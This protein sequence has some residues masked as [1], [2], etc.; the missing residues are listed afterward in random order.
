MTLQAVT[1]LELE[2]N[3]VCNIHSR[4]QPCP[5]DE[6]VL[7]LNNCSHLNGVSL[8]ACG[9][10]DGHIDGLLHM[11]GTMYRWCVATFSSGLSN[12][13]SPVDQAPDVRV[14]H[15]NVN[16]DAMCEQRW[17]T[18]HY[19]ATKSSPC[20]TCCVTKDHWEPSA[21]SRITITC[22]SGQATTDTKT[23]PSTAT[24]VS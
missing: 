4:V 5:A 8:W 14:V 11:L 17:P 3:S 15:I 21:C 12:I 22:A 24:Q 9:K 10:L 1:V 20:C 6:S 18:A 19:P 16:I 13:P 23:P 2:V 7:L